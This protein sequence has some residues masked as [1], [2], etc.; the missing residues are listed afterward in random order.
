MLLVCPASTQLLITGAAK[1]GR[2][3]RGTGGRDWGETGDPNGY[4]TMVNARHF[5]GRGSK[6]HKA[7]TPEQ[8]EAAVSSDWKGLY[9]YQPH[10][11]ARVAIASVEGYPGLNPERRKE[12]VKSFA[13]TAID[14]PEK[15]TAVD[16]QSGSGQVPTLAMGN[17][18]V[19][20]TYEGEQVLLQRM[21]QMPH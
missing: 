1:A 16:N 3:L 19:S 9:R 21:Q 5:E 15:K 12:A 10:T 14:S 11:G 2:M 7:L 8:A 6:V 18:A 13:R 20:M 17:A 4:E